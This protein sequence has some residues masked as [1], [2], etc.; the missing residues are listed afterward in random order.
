MA[1]RGQPLFIANVGAKTVKKQGGRE[2]EVPLWLGEVLPGD[3][4]LRPI[5]YPLL[6]TS[7]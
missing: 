3:Y 4:H 2:R 6:P 1:P 5:G 7:W